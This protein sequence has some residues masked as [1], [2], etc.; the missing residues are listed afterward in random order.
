MLADLEDLDDVGVFDRGDRL[1]FRLEPNEIL[2]PRAGAGPD[3][4]QGDEPVEPLLA[5]LVDDPHP[6]RAQ[7]LQDLVTGDVRPCIDRAV[8]RREQRAIGII[9]PR[10]DRALKPGMKRSDSIRI[11]SRRSIGSRGVVGQLEVAEPIQPLSGRGSRDQSGQALLGVAAM[12]VDVF[13][14]ER[15]DQVALRG[16]QG[17]LSDEELGQRPASVRGPGPGARRE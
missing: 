15:L 6:T 7:H 8:C 3:H 4:L 1:G 5:R 17:T 11:A 13:A 10:I 12:P 14:G 2:G 16:R 9:E